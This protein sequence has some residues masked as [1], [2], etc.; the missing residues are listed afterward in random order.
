M[1]IKMRKPKRKSI[2]RGVR[3]TTTVLITAKI[4]QLKRNGKRINARTAK[5][6]GILHQYV[7]PI[8]QKNSSAKF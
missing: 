5:V 3:K 7:H 8:F 2:A 6:L 4:Q 1:K